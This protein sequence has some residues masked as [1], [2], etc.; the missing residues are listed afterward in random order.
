MRA[1]RSAMARS[2]L[3]LWRLDQLRRV[4]SEFLYSSDDLLVC[5]PAHLWC[6]AQ[7]PKIFSTSCPFARSLSN[8]RQ[9]SARRPQKMPQ[10][11]A[12]THRVTL[13]PATPA[14]ASAERPIT[15]VSLVAA[16][17][18]YSACALSSSRAWRRNRCR[19]RHPRR[20]QPCSASAP[21]RSRERPRAPFYQYPG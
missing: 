4:V 12:L 11:V 3:R 7:E 21:C 1:L 10:V 5:F 14:V 9:A 19:V 20:G 16:S 15:T 13:Q 17:R 18:R 2:T 6:P 8:T